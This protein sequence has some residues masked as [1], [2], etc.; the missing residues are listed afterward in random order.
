VLDRGEGKFVSQVIFQCPSD[1][2]KGVLISPTVHG[3]LIVGPNAE[4]VPDPERRETT[5]AGLA[6]VRKAASRSAG[7][8]PTTP[9]S[10]RSQACG[11]RRTRTISSSARSRARPASSTWLASSPRAH[12]GPAIAQH[13]AGLVQERFGP[14]P[15]RPGFNPLR[16]PMI[17]FASLSKEEK[18]A[19]IRKDPRFGR[20]V[21]RCESVTEGEV[22]DAI[23]RKAGATTVDGVKRRVRP[24][25]GRC[26][27]GFCGPRVME[28]L[29]RELGV[30]MTAVRKDG[31]DSILLLGPTKDVREAVH[32]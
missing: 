23:H 22:V 6:E 19:W 30:P 2:G 32:A 17:H 5:L 12:L 1:K 3:N 16:R 7:R 10:R 29:A 11:P 4:M 31:P 14:L 21:C 9:P 15:L 28:I 18:A 25:M 27:G 8:S 24:G 13:V 20:M 26:Q